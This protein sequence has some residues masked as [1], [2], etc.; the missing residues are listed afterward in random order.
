MSKNW[1]ESGLVKMKIK[2]VQWRE[3]LA[4]YRRRIPHDLLKHYAGETHLFFSLQTKDFREAAKRAKEQTKQLDKRWDLLRAS[5][6]SDLEIREKAKVILGN[7]N[8]EPGQAAEYAKHGLEPDAFIG[9]LLAHSQDGNG[10]LRDIDR[11]RLPKD[12]RLAADLFYAD[13]KEL[14]ELTVP[15]F[16]EVQDKHLYFYPKKQ[17]DPQFERSVARFLEVNGDLPVNK[18]QRQHGNAFV[19]ALMDSGVKAATVKR[20]LNQIRPIFE[21]A[22]SELEVSMPNPLSQLKVPK[23]EA[24]EE[25]GREPF[26]LSEVKAVQSCCRQVD[27]PRRWVLSLLSDT[28]ARLSEIAGLLVKDVCLDQETPHISIR[29]NQLRGLKT[30]TS[31]RSVP[32]VGEA[33]WAIHRALE[34]NPSEYL[35]PALVKNGEFNSN[36]VSAALNKWLKDQDLRGPKQTV[37]SFRHSIRDRL[38]NSGCPPDVADRIGGWKRQGVGEG[39][40]VGHDL[41]VMHK[42]MTRMISHEIR[43]S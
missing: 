1:F 11:E 41:I 12:L 31:E 29:R 33:L 7:Y 5:D 39:Y 28:G 24:D 27:D 13:P 40:G 2:Y 8:L 26:S 38:R 32:L 22:I 19:K 15:I 36:S 14:R 25:R 3:G 35:F 9:E 18:Y 10:A 37:H 20:Y 30:V 6:G 17:S 21:T 42:A 43:K 16:T 4:Y 23:T 34:D